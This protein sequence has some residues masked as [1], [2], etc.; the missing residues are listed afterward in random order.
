MDSQITA[1]CDDVLKALPLWLFQC[2]QRFL[3]GVDIPRRQSG[4]AVPS[5]II[6]RVTNPMVFIPGDGKSIRTLTVD[7]SHAEQN[8]P[9]QDTIGQN[10]M[11]SVVQ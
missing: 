9:T 4:A 8:I 6:V 5:S 7:G 2:R 3:S 10:S 1:L 11:L